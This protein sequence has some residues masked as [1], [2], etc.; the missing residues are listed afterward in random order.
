MG[1]ALLGFHDWDATAKAWVETLG[2]AG[3][4]VMIGADNDGNSVVEAIRE[5]TDERF[6]VGAEEL[7]D[8]AV[9][10]AQHVGVELVCS[11]LRVSTSSSHSE[12]KGRGTRDFSECRRKDHE[13]HG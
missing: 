8:A 1:G 6:A 3:R 7:H 2:A 12:G 10:L 11:P 13:C 5:K 4:A 9:E